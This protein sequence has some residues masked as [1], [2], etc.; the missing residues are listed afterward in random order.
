MIDMLQLSLKKWKDRIT[1]KKI[2]K[3]FNHFFLAFVFFVYLQGKKLKF[4]TNIAAFALK[5][6][7]FFKKKKARI[8]RTCNR[9]KNIKKFVS[10]SARE[11]REKNKTKQNKQHT[12]LSKT[13]L[14][15][16]KKKNRVLRIKKTS[17][18]FGILE[19]GY[20]KR[21]GD[22]LAIEQVQELPFIR[23]YKKAKSKKT[24]GGNSTQ[25]D[26]AVVSLVIE[27]DDCC[28]GCRFRYC[29]LLHTVVR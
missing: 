5:S 23:T 25:K 26:V 11:E 7:F 18:D 6:I 21:Y 29:K 20:H 12:M 28:N 17:L 15:Q 10:E 16:T 24:N 14:N 27:L 19:E 13:K 4:K 9:S 3:L 22:S 1:I 2:V 8:C